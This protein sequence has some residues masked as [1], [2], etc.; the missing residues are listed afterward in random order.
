MGAAGYAC[1]T[2]DRERSRDR[3][4]TERGERSRAPRHRRLCCG[5]RG[6]G[7]GCRGRLCCRG[8]SFRAA[9]FDGR[10]RWLAAG[11]ERQS[12]DSDR[13][14]ARE[15][16]QALEASM[17]EVNMAEVNM[18]AAGDGYRTSFALHGT[19]LSRIARQTAPQTPCQGAL[20]AFSRSHHDSS[21]DGARRST[22]LAHHFRL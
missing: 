5:G 13:K 7:R 14:P 10:A 22:K 20:L 8:G 15:A 2:E 19:S 1:S 9:R 11:R 12:Q 4:I 3:V 17:A 21:S 16:F 18:A 6:S